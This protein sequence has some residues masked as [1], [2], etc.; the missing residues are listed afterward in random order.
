MTIIRAVAILF[1]IIE[2]MIFVYVILTWFIRDRDHP[3]MR[4][5]GVFIDPIM[6]PVDRLLIKLGFNAG[7]ISFTPIFALLALRFI[8]LLVIMALNQV[9]F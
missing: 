6:V 9:L 2:F 7:F 4:L 5:L 1:E 8:K 3:V